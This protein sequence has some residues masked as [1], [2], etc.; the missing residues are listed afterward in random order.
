MLLREMERL[1]P[2]VSWV[3]F[4]EGVFAYAVNRPAESERALARAGRQKAGG[5]WIWHDV[6][7]Q[8]LH[9]LGRFEEQYRVASRGLE[10]HPTIL[11]LHEHQAAALAALGRLQDLE[12][13]MS[14][15]L[16]AQASSGTAGL[17]MLVASMEL[18]AHGHREEADAL[19]TRA[20]EWYGSASLETFR[21][22]QTP[23]RG[24][25]WYRAWPR[26][27]TRRLREE[28][29]T[30]LYWAERWAE[31]E[32][33]VRALAKEEPDNVE[34][35][36]RLATL[37][38]R[39]GRQGEARRLAGPLRAL[40][41]RDLFGRDAFWRAAIAA[42]LGEKKEAVELLNEAFVRGHYFQTHLHRNID[43]EPLWDYSPFQELL[44][45][46]G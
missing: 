15:A 45:P 9:L 38:A 8:S 17:V 43:F 37:A 41:P 35:L 33:I 27:L 4:D 46:K 24:I 11:Y 18:R 10:E 2:G 39:T 5:G 42:Q 34:Y 26:D 12:R 20:A 40:D 36:G 6:Y 14:S 1:A 23:N 32:A 21:T 31:A 25:E 16:R 30:A 7:A 22:L 44:R 3:P 29:A 13:V 19:A 28:H